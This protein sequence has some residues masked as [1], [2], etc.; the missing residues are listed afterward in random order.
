MWLQAECRKK[1]RLVIFWKTCNLIIS[2]CKL[3][4]FRE[5]DFPENVSMDT[6]THYTHTGRS[7]DGPC[8]P[9]DLLLAGGRRQG[10]RG[11]R[12]YTG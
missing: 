11:T 5:V 4:L 2:V 7:R 12:L 8:L 3:V 10:E 1:C 9:G 6:R